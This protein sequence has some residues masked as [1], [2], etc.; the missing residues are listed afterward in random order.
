MAR[1]D[2]SPGQTCLR[3]WLSTQLMAKLQA[4]AERLGICVSEATRRA[5]ATYVTSGKKGRR[6]WEKKKAEKEMEA[7][8]TKATI[9]RMLERMGLYRGEG[10][11]TS[12]PA[13]DHLQGAGPGP[14]RVDGAPVSGEDGVR[15]RVA[16]VP[17]LEGQSEGEAEAFRGHPEASDQA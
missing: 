8:P 6:K 16:P 1:G 10:K 13:G 7:K 9:R 17:A 12:G 14:G 11:D 5:L 4:E 3:V 15:G 2:R